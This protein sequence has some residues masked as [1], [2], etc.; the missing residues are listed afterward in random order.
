MGL[1]TGRLFS[2][3]T[4]ALAYYN[5]DLIRAIFI[6]LSQYAGTLATVGHFNPSFIFV[7]K[8]GRLPHRVG[9]MGLSFLPSNIRLG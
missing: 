5:K 4:N 9:S 8:A 3:L 2:C 6:T 7:G 1:H